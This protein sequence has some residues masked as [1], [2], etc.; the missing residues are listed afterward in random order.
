VFNLHLVKKI[1]S[2]FL[3]V[4][5][6]HC[7]LKLQH[8]YLISSINALFDYVVLSIIMQWRL[9]KQSLEPN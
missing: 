7:C 9:S 8:V 5:G 2:P 3:V 1:L 4:F 6:L